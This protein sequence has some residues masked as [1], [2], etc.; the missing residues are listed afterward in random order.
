[1]RVR[2]DQAWHHHASGCIYL[3]GAS[4]SWRRAFADA[5]D[6]LAFGA[7]PSMHARIAPGAI[8]QETIVDEQGIHHRILHLT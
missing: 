2:I 5:S 6:A 8:D 1:M 3:G 4:D 7:H